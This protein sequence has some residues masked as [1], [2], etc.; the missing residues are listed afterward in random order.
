MG[1]GRQ[2]SYG[3]SSLVPNLRQ[4]Q[5]LKK[6]QHLVMNVLVNDTREP[7][8]TAL[9][10]RGAAGE[11][12]RILGLSYSEDVLEQIFNRFCIGK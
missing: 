1:V 6:A 11:L 2:L 3:A 4:A 7:E 10:L 12:D 8:L 5:G 9:D